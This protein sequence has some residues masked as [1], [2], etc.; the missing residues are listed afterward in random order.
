MTDLDDITGQDS[1]SSQDAYYGKYRGVV[2]SNAD[3][4]QT[5]RLLVEVS[6]VAGI[7][8][9]SWAM[10]CLPFAGT[11]SGFFAVPVVGS[12][13]WVEFEQGDPDYPIWTGCFWGTVAELPAL[14]QA[15]PP[16]VQQIVM[17]T[18]GQNILMISDVPGPDGGI[19]LSSS[20]GALISIS[21]LGI[22]IDNGQ[23]ASVILADASV[24]I[25]DGA[26]EVM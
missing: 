8:P 16:G 17:Q 6:D 18:V 7:L 20:S 21:D 9:S 24:S 22:M 4:M 25:N 13:V 11:Q 12:K 3:P 1:V 26:L 19:L 14:A 23:G 5:G 2:L 10:P 15:A